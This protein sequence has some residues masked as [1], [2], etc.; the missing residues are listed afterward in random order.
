MIQDYLHDNGLEHRHFGP[1]T[2]EETFRWREAYQRSLPEGMVCQPTDKKKT[3]HFANGS[4]TT[5]QIVV[6]EIPIYLKGHTGEVYSAE[7]PDG[8]TPLLLSIAAMTALDMVLRVREQVVEVGTL[9]LKLPMLKT[10]SKHLAIWI[11][12]NPEEEAV[13]PGDSPRVVS[14]KDDLFVYYGQEARWSVLSDLPHQHYQQEPDKFA[15]VPVT[16]PRGVR[17]GDPMENLL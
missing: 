7:V 14:E 12:R 9:D 1:A 3:F 16:E 10:R 15:I 4:S 2:S 11:A 5:E 8:A 6:W 17:P 13:V